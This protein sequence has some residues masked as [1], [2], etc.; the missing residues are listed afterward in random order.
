M[1]TKSTNVTLV[2]TAEHADIAA[3][4]AEYFT[5]QEFLTLHYRVGTDAPDLI[6]SRLEAADL[7]IPILFPIAEATEAYS[8]VRLAY[9]VAGRLEEE[10]EVAT[11]PVYVT[12]KSFP[13]LGED[14][15][16]RPRDFFSNKVSFFWYSQAGQE[17]N[18][19]AFDLK[20]KE[21]LRAKEAEAAETEEKKQVVR[22]SASEYSKEVIAGLTAREQIL[23]RISIVWS[24]VGFGAIV[25]GMVIAS[26][27]FA[28]FGGETS[29]WIPVVSRAVKYAFIAALL[30]AAAR[31]AFMF[32]RAY[33]NEAMKAADRI[34]AVRFGDLFLK[35]FEQS[36]TKEDFKE[37]FQFWNT[38]GDNSILALKAEEFDPKV[39]ENLRTLLGKE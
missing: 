29:E 25:A 22:Q 30:A 13:D 7:V 37:V 39:L 15:V 9:E 21:L 6:R 27:A 26:T 38:K 35:I 34:H 16:R 17:E 14:Q 28:K 23:R 20:M 18:I 4:L 5:S 33:M 8:E 31:Y 32:A 1:L 10:R 24:V 12:P 2:Y 19:T 36:F 11:L 3:A